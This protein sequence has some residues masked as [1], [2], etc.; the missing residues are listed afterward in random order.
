MRRPKTL[1]FERHRDVGHRLAQE[2]DYLRSLG[3]EVGNTYGVTAK[4][5]RLLEKA[6]RALNALRCELDNRVCAEHGERPYRE[7]SNAYYGTAGSEEKGREPVLT[8]VQKRVTKALEARSSTKFAD[9]M[10]RRW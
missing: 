1:T 9:A 10:I 7:L 8:D 2:Q 4:A 5:T 6:E 3:V